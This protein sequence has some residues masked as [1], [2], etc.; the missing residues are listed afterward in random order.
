MSRHRAVRNLD[1]DDILDDEDYGEDY[2]ENDFNEDELSNEDLDKLDEGLA[3]VY[4]VIGDDTF[5][6]AKEIREALWE[7]YFDKEETVEWALERAKQQKSSFFH[8]FYDFFQLCITNPP[9]T[10][11]AENNKSTSPSLAALSKARQ[12]ASS[13]TTNSL[14]QLKQKM[15]AQTESQSPSLASLAASSAAKKPLSSLQALAQRSST[16]NTTPSLVSLAKKSSTSTNKAPRLAHLTSR[17]PTIQSD[18]SKL[19]ALAG[20]AS[21]VKES[22]KI[23]L[24]YPSKS[25]SLEPST[26]DKLTTEPA[27]RQSVVINAEENYSNPLCGKPSFAAQFLFAPQEPIPFDAQAVFL[28]GKKSE[29]I[30]AFKFDQ[31]SPDD[32][33][34]A[35]QSN[36]S[37]NARSK[38]S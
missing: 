35:A 38:R 24:S 19:S 13:S 17:P 29:S 2:D 8:L 20:L 26:K 15:G 11:M 33:V 25:I 30:S 37:G 4:S 23:T 12:N 32:I 14:T 31:P 22:P 10:N 27:E 36:F 6:T 9:R 5:L 16:G 1:V 21:S 3:Y 7:F 34:L 28:E 18:P